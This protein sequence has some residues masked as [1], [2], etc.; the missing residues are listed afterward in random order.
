MQK[1]LAI[2][3]ALERQVVHFLRVAPEIEQL[4]VVVRDQ[5]AQDQ[6]AWK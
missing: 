3:F 6:W 5:Y 1:Y 2:L 4:H